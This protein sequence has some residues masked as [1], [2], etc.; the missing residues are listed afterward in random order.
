MINFPNSP[1]VGARWPTDPQGGKQWEWN[2]Y[3][4]DSL[5]ISESMVQ[6]AETASASAF[7]SK[8]EAAASAA[9]SALSQTDAAGSATA[10][11]SSATASAVSAAASSASKDASADSATAAG[12]KASEA[13]A[14]AAAA[15]ASKNAAATSETNA[16]GSATAAATS[17]GN[18]STSAG[19]ASTSAG[20]ASTSAGA[21][22]TSAGNAATA[23]TAA[24]TSATL[25][26]NWAT[27]T[28]GE[29]ATGQGFSAKKYAQ[30][31]A[32]SATQA[33]ADVLGK[34]LTGL[35]LATGTAITAADTVLS[36]FGKLQK[37]ITD[38]LSALAPKASPTFTGQV[39]VPEGTASVPGLAFAN[40]GS[41]DTGFWH[42]SDGVFGATCNTEQIML[43]KP[44]GVELKSIPRA[45]TATAGTSDTRVAT[46]EFTAAAVSAAKTTLEPN[47]QTGTSYTLV[48]SDAGK[49][50]AMS[51]AAANVVTVPPNSAVAFPV[52]TTIF[53]S[54]DGAGASSVAAGAGVTINTAEGLKVGAQYKMISLIKTA[55]DTWMA[56]GSTA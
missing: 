13:S 5:A 33:A 35:S 44:E 4:W 45:P 9:Q 53:V 7:N 41:P 28:D 15:L 20:N 16:S 25:A 40:D 43:F 48:L 3:A 47:A 8:T 39:I 54:Q 50:V 18:A 37:Q 51:N 11:A 49:R 14:S 26:Q 42:V 29:V 1:A 34:V 22:S 23:A 24:G 30:D 12:T 19:A 55:T 38:A 6:S 2:G 32:A 31:A 21:A 17:A 36:A 52:N 10:A 27:K 46:T 56:I